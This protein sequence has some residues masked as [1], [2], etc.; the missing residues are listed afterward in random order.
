MHRQH[1]RLRQ[2]VGDASAALGCYQQLVGYVSYRELPRV[3]LSLL[4]QA[5]SPCR[6]CWLRGRRGGNPAL[7]LLALWQRL[8]IRRTCDEAHERCGGY[9]P[10][11]TW[12]FH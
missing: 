1:A 6:S 8:T 9:G 7:L 5:G 3:E 11:Q 4:P 10:S 2:E 12:F